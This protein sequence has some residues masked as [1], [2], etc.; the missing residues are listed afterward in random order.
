MSDVEQDMAPEGDM[1][2]LLEHLKEARG[3]DSS[4]YKRPTLGRRIEK[5]MVEVGFASYDAY[6]DYLE[7]NPLEV[8]ELL[9][10]ILIN[11]TG[12]F[13]DR[14]AWDFLATTVLPKL[15]EAVPDES[16]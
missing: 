12:F 1:E 11:V 14:P 16:P 5:R 10:A 4:G 6:Q 15:I 3:F 2:T 8:T 7:A 13:R 9:N